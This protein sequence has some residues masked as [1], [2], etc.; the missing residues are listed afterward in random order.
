MYDEMYSLLDSIQKVNRFEMTLMF[1]SRKDKQGKYYKIII[2]S[3]LYIMN[4]FIFIKKKK[5]FFSIKIFF[6][7]IKRNF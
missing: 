2:N 3:S 5:N 1:M 7:S 6:I 4:K